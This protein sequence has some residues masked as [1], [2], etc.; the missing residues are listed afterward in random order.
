[1]KR[2]S[3]VTLLIVLVI[4]ALS[5]LIATQLIEHG[6]YSQRRTQ[7][8][9]AREQA[10]QLALGGEALAK[11]W[12]AKGFGKDSIVHL[13]Q[14]WATTPFEYPVEGGFI[15]A[16]VKD[17]QTCFNLNS[18]D[19]SVQTQSANPSPSP[20]AQ[21]PGQKDIDQTIYENLVNEVLKSIDG[22]TI[23]PQALVASLVD[24]IDEDVE[25]LL[26][27]G[28]EDMTYTGYELPYRTGNGRLADKSELRIIS[29]YSAK[30]YQALK[31]YVCVLP[32]PSINQININTLTEEQAP[33]LYAV[34]K[35]QNIG[36]AEAQQIISSRPEKG[37]DSVG[38]ALQV[39]GNTKVD[40]E[41]QKRLDVSSDH[42]IVSITVELKGA[43]FKMKTL[44][45]RSSQQQ[46]APF[47]VLA[48]YFGEF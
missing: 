31:D 32:D 17:A 33:I 44:L 34:I 5:T 40:A 25:P 36:L 13:Q 30:V 14:P 21:S 28:A 35:G 20:K 12:L 39:L 9:L 42:F 15:K 1:M 26:P 16:T 27:D 38:E 22:I 8:V 7:L 10:Y 4:V 37:Y 18:L 11:K 19:P 3:G 48:R 46:D 2:Q 23:Q 47:T 41:A 43:A 24:W 45:K 29:G 6:T